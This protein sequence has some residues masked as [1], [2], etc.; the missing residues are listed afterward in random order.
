[1]TVAKSGLGCWPQGAGRMPQSGLNREGSLGC[2]GADKPFKAG[3]PENPSEGRE[4]QQ[5]G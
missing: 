5:K 1:M 2:H 3:L 4:V